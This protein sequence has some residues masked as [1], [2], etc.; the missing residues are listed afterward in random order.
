[1]QVTIGQWM[2]ILPP[3]RSE[4]LCWIEGKQGLA[5]IPVLTCQSV[6]LSTKAIED[7]LRAGF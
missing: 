2:E 5:C 7:T 6:D 1:M 4:L 3:A